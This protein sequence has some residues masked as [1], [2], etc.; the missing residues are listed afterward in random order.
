MLKLIAEIMKQYEDSAITAEE[1]EN[2]IANAVVDLFH[3]AE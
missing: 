3:W 2:A 1:A